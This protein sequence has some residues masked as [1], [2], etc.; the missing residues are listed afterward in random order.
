MS[1]PQLDRMLRRP[2]ASLTDLRAL[3][4]VGAHGRLRGA[5]G[6]LRVTDSAVSHQLR[7]LE[8]QVGTRLVDRSPDGA[9]LTPAGRRLADA[10]ARAT[11]LL[12]DA[13][14]EIRPA[15]VAT[16]SLTLP[17]SLATSWLAPRFADLHRTHPEIE[18]VLLPTQRRV[19]LQ[20]EHVDLAIRYGDPG[21][22]LETRPLFTETCF[23]VAA[24]DEA[25]R[26]RADGWEGRIESEARLFE[27]QLHAGEWQAWCAPRGLSEPRE[28]QVRRLGSSDL[29]LEVARVGAGLV[30]GRTPMVERDL[31]A[32]ALVR[33]FA[34]DE[35]PGVPYSLVW[36]R[37]RV[38][39]A[40]AAT[41][42]TWLEGQARPAGA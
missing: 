37:G 17:R 1:D 18:L 24:P 35:M 22:D 32:G 3:I 16:V 9:A 34:D 19:D 7:R 40:A 13:L 27:N 10:A 5:A 15:A 11:A 14:D 39:T 6:A 12:V 31:A 29:L 33:P 28:G 21:R 36:P 42:A 8:R 38:P 41:V 20:R 2:L 30:M 26:W 23:P 4:A 25:E